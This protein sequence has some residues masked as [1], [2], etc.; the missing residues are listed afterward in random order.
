MKDVTPIKRK[1]NL[2]PL[3]RDHHQGLL[4]VWKIRQGLKTDATLKE[5]SAYA[6]WFW[7]QHLAPHFLLEEKYLLTLLPVAH[8]LALR[9][10]AEHKSIHEAILSIEIEPDRNELTRL[11]DLLETHIRFEEREYFTYLE[12]ILDDNEMNK[13]VVFEQEHLP[14]CKE[15]ENEFW[16]KNK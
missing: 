1:V 7:E 3:S 14:A 8:P 11:C 5:M 6:A 12:D 16:K 2:Q 13:L 4:F 15:W 10:L 9:M